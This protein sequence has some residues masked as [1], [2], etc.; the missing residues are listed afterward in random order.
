MDGL[1]KAGSVAPE[2][3]NMRADALS[4]MLGSEAFNEQKQGAFKRAKRLK[5]RN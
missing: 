1:R 2:I 3:V 5:K 4:E